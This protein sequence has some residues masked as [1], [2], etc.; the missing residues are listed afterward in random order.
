MKSE[1]CYVF[2]IGNRFFYQFTKKGCKTAWCIS[3]AKR[4]QLFNRLPV[5]NAYDKLILL[6]KKPIVLL[7]GVV[8][9]IDITNIS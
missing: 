3:G 5:F 7:L 8:D 4:F 6:K 9:T 1:L 2:K